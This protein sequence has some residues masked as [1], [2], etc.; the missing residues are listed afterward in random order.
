MNSMSSAYGGNATVRDGDTVLE[1][2]TADVGFRGLNKEKKARIFNIPWPSDSPPPPYA[3]LLSIASAHGLYAAASPDALVIG[4]TQDL[5]KHIYENADDDIR[6]C[7]PIHTVPHSRLAQV[8]FS[9]D[10]S[11]LVVAEEKSSE[12]VAYIS[13]Q[14]AAHQS[15]AA[16]RLSTNAPIRVIAPNPDPGSARLFAL[17]N[18]DDQLLLADLQMKQLMP[19][20]N[21]PVLADGVTCVTWSNKGKQLVAGRR[22]GTALILKTD[23]SV[24]A[25]VPKPSSVPANCH[26]ATISW[27]END[28]FFMVW[29]PSEVLADEPPISEYF[30]IKQV[31]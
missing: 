7:A 21:G 17:V 10:E 1:V 16:L 24:V 27:T 9:S 12:V 28:V 11:C 3:S 31:E 30:I 18:A 29:T 8:A 25:T 4:K 19:G 6:V 20:P 14:L 13:S 23:G 26:V 22:D 5:R 2:I 15:D